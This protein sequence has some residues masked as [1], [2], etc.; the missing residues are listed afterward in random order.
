MRNVAQKVESL[1][2]LVGTLGSAVHRHEDLISG[3]LSNIGTAAA[4][5]QDGALRLNAVLKRTDAREIEAVLHNLLDGAL[6]NYEQELSS[7]SR[8]DIRGW[9]NKHVQESISST[10]DSL[11]SELKHS[12]LE[13]EQQSKEKPGLSANTSE[14]MIN[15]SSQT[16]EI[17]DEAQGQQWDNATSSSSANVRGP[18]A[19]PILSISFKQR[20]TVLGLFV[21]RVV[22]RSKWQTVNLVFQPIK[23]DSWGLDL[24]CK[25][26]FDGR[27]LPMI[28]G[29]ELQLY[30]IITDQDPIWGLIHNGDVEGLR[31][32]LRSKAISVFDRTASYSLTLLH[33]SLLQSSRVSNETHD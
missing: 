33:V 14:R 22:P 31:V 26:C 2:N 4:Q 11:L 19:E 3:S 16:Q 13:H 12:I 24:S 15:H 30:G 7:G 29:G 6:S 32:G 1:E 20:R 25:Y 10:A 21:L 17:D 9:L 28:R 23:F 18:D 5:V 8:R 27:G